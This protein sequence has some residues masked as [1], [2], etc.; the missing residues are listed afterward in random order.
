MSLTS[1]RT[2][3]YRVELLTK[4][5]ES[6]GTL[7]FIEGGSLQ[8]NSE[9]DLPAGGRIL[10]EGIDPSLTPNVS[11]DR[12]RIWWE[13]EGETPWA[14]GVYVMA[15]PS[16]LYRADGSSR[17]ITLIDKL[18]V[19]RDDL[20]VSTLQ[21]TSG[22][23]II[24]AVKAQI[25]ASGETRIAA[26]ASSAVLANNMTWSPGTSRLKVINDLL[27]AANYGLLWTDRVGQFRVEPYVAPE[28]RAVVW[29]FEEG[30]TSIHSPNWQ[31]DLDLWKATNRVVLVSQ[32]D[33]NGVVKVAYA[34][35]D[36]PDSPTSTVSMGR[37]L[38][39]IVQEN[40][41]AE[42]QLAL[43]TQANRLLLENSNVVGKLTVSHAAIPVWYNEAVS[44]K[45]QGMNTRAII[46]KMS[47]ELKPGAL[48][49]AEWR[50]A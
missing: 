13:V 29:N 34:T 7:G 44:F 45:S 26:T 5:D 24:Q 4:A 20:L 42:S 32:A 37:T 47:L 10:L 2:E 33:S 46:T 36:N 50:Q 3:G 22:T 39:P 38:N 41:E 16:T 25:M 49:N 21:I 31:Y 12:V 8:W 48:V 27:T 14:L 11:K 15:S 28:S 19:I 40:V 30:S 23:N 18:I 35:D 43:Q 6:L 9:A 1:H 17:D